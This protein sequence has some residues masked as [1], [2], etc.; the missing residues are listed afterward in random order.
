M[1]KSLRPS[2]AT[3]PRRAAF[4]APAPPPRTRSSRRPIVTGRCARRCH[5][6]SSRRSA[7]PTAPLKAWPPRTAGSHQ[8]LLR[9]RRRG[10]REHRESQ[11]GR[12]ETAAPAATG[13]PP[14]AAAG[15]AAAAPPRRR[16]R[17]RSPRWRCTRPRSPRPRGAGTP[18]GRWGTL[19]RPW[20]PRRRMDVRGRERPTARTVR[21]PAA[22]LVRAKGRVGLRSEP[23]CPR[24]APGW[25]RSATRTTAPSWTASAATVRCTPPAAGEH[26]TSPPVSCEG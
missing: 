22:R 3:A 26:P 7:T 10:R 4:D 18:W 16:G 15:P 19:R 12:P 13:R 9:L 1:T 24:P 25:Q 6:R 23:H 8:T 11:T 5:R 20:R 14:H 17:T 21:R 2:A